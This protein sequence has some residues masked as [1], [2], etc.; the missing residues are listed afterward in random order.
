MTQE[1]YNQLDAD[2]AYCTGLYCEKTGKC[3]QYIVLTGATSVVSSPFHC[4]FL[5]NHHGKIEEI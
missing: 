3:Q 4:T 5:Q 1:E 2:L